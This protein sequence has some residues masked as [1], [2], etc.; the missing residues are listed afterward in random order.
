M[1]G[2]ARDD[3]TTEHCSRWYSEYNIY[4][5]TMLFSL[6]AAVSIIAGAPRPVWLVLVASA[7]AFFIAPVVFFLNLYYCFTVIPKEDKRFYPSAVA[8][9]CAWGSLAVFTGLTALLI[10]ARIFRIEFFRS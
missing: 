1:R 4:R 5:A 9:W 7:L 6:I 8:T 10:L 2:I 3:L